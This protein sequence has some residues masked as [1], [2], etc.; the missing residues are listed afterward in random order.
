MIQQDVRSRLAEAARAIDSASMAFER[1]TKRIKRMQA[2]GEDASKS[3]AARDKAEW[4]LQ[5]WLKQAESLRR[6][7]DRA[8]AAVTR[9]LLQGPTEKQRR[10]KQKAERQRKVSNANKAKVL[11]SAAIKFDPRLASAER[12]LHIDNL[13]SASRARSLTYTG[14]FARRASDATGVRVAACSAFDDLW[15]AAHVGDFPEPRFEPRVD[16][17]RAERTHQEKRAGAKL[18]LQAIRTTIGPYLY[19]IAE[20]RIIQNLSY[21]ALSKHVDLAPH[22][23]PPKFIRAVDGIADVL[24]LAVTDDRSHSRI[25]AFRNSDDERTKQA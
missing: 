8:Q 5:K 17:T 19:A 10:D 1:H 18:S 6:S 15:Q 21:S 3:I 20:Q 9:P 24:G 25:R 13:G 7:A 16:A 23:L 12:E 4:K 11:S 22:H 14:L 2:K